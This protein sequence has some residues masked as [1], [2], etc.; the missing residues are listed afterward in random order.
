MIYPHH[1][2]M[3]KFGKNVFMADNAVAIGE[4][5]FGDDASIWFGAIVRGDVNWIKI[6]SRTNIQDG[7][8]CHVTLNKWPLNIGNN[9]SLGHGA[10]VHGC[11]I[12]DGTLIGMGAKVL[13]GAEIGTNCMVAAGALVKEGTKIPPGVL[14]AGIP[15]VIKRDLRQDEISGLTVLA[16]RYVTYK[17]E[18][19]AATS[20]ENPAHDNGQ[21]QQ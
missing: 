6:G 8:I 9:V 17:N 20:E 10:I 4:V 18:Y 14:V 1:N 11:T 21:G 3:P 7:A 19:L 13:D 16:N 5:E 15:A 2:C 12:K